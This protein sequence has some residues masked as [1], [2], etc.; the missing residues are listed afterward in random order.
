MHAQQLRLEVAHQLIRRPGVANDAVKA[1]G[2][3]RNSGERTQAEPDHGAFDPLACAR[4]NCVGWLSHG[5]KFEFGCICANDGK[6][7]KVQRNP[8]G[9]TTMLSMQGGLIGL[10]I[11]VLDVYCIIR[12]LGTTAS[13]G[14]KVLWVVIILILPVLGPILW[15]LFG[16]K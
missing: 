12:V 8:W 1:R 14:T 5:G 10:A 6:F 9:G 7:S 2:F 15:F 11:L 3:V 16:P 4:Q 13:T